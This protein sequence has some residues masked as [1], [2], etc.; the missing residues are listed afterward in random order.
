MSKRQ[1]DNGQPPVPP[2]TWG[3]AQAG[4]WQPGTP[5]APGGQYV[6]PKKPSWVA[7]HKVLTGLAGLVVIGGMAAAG[8]SGSGAGSSEGASRPAATAMTA[9]TLEGTS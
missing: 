5:P 1:N 7:R 3:S 2:S 6:Q 8:G 9:A 4:E